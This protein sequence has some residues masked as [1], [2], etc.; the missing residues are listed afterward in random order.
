MTWVGLQCLAVALSGHTHLPF[1]VHLLSSTL[2]NPHCKYHQ[3]NF[4]VN[5]YHGNPATLI[6]NQSSIYALF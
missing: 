4:D 2:K 6:E 5:V 1:H 3:L